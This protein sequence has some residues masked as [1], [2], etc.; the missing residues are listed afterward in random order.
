MFPFT[1]DVV[2]AAPSFGDKSCTI[3][4]AV[5]C[6]RGWTAYGIGQYTKVNLSHTEGADTA[7]LTLSSSWSDNVDIR[8]NKIAITGSLSNSS[9]AGNFNI[10]LKDSVFVGNISNTTTDGY[11]GY[12]WSTFTFDGNY[13][14]TGSNA[15]NGYALVGDIIGDA[16]TRFFFKNGAK[17]K[18]DYRSSENNNAGTSVTLNF[19]DGSSLEG[20]NGSNGATNKS[21][22]SLKERTLTINAYNNS[23]INAN[24]TTGVLNGYTKPTFNLN[25][26][27]NS[28]FNGTINSTNLANVTAT[29]SSYN[30]DFISKKEGELSVALRNTLDFR[31]SS[32]T[33]GIKILYNSDGYQHRITG[34]FLGNGTATNG[35][36][37]YALKGNVTNQN[38][39]INLTFKDGAIW[40][41]KYTA[42]QRTSNTSRVQAVFNFDNATQKDSNSNTISNNSTLL[43]INAKNNSKVGAVTLN[44]NTSNINFDTKST[45][46]GLTISGGTNNVV[47]K[48]GSSIGTNGLN[49]SGGTSTI[50]FSDSSSVNGNINLTNGTSTLNIDAKNTSFKD[51]KA[52]GASTKFIAN[53]DTTSIGA[54]QATN[55]ASSANFKNMAGL[56]IGKISGD[57]TDT[58]SNGYAGTLTGV[59]DFIPKANGTSDSEAKSLSISDIIIKDNN[60]NVHL[61]LNFGGADSDGKLKGKNSNTTISNIKGGGTNSSVVFSDV[62]SF[63]FSKAAPTNDGSENSDTTNATNGYKGKTLDIALKDATNID[64][65]SFNGALGLEKTSIILDTNSALAK[66]TTSSGSNDSSDSSGSDSSAQTG[67]LSDS[68]K[69]L[70][71]TFGN[72]TIQKDSMGNV[73]YDSANRPMILANDNNQSFT[74]TQ[75][76]KTHTKK[77]NSNTNGNTNGITEYTDGYVEGVSSDGNIGFDND[78]F[79]K[80]IA[81]VYKDGTFKSGQSGYTGTILGGTA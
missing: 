75:S 59:L 12:G 62:G 25:L 54:L 74:L 20:K 3:G 77:E 21:N 24:V 39:I 29:N 41:G 79:K 72:A 18:G 57:G 38:G 23:T 47:F 61:T 68:T 65:S 34:T 17:M 78:N 66:S 70:S 22:I 10:I 11:T 76:G 36:G 9:N 32:F 2:Q 71:I 60:N 4:S 56:S 8:A 19:T 27:N 7:T 37:Q 31:H 26:V 5:S 81:F 58:T 51:I 48:G 52:T 67:I 55:S 28:T 50:S 1:G 49:V 63:D 46:K 80:T 45:L 64:V 69:N 14:G 44:G 40:D 73:V 42:Q 53:F 30:G 13:Q 43:T 33:G 16:N 6:I 15:N 35:G